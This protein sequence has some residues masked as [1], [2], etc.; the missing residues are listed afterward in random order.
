VSTNAGE[1]SWYVEDG[2]YLR[3]QYLSI[4]YALPNTLIKP[5]GLSRAKLNVA[6]TNLLTF[7]KYQGLDPG[8][9][10]DVDTNFGVDVG[11]YPVTRGLT[12]SLNIGF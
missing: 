6:A 5:L 4:G 1:N 9:G 7:T 11:N 3:V 8:V 12:F 2:S 10:G